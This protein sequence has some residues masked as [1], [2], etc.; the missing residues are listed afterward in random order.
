MYASTAQSKDNLDLREPNCC[1]GNQSDFSAIYSSWRWMRH[2]NNLE[3]FEDRDI[4]LNPL[5]FGFG[6]KRIRLSLQDSGNMLNL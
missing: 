3:L 4:G 1:A 2:S 6:I 5:P